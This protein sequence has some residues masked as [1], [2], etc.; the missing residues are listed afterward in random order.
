MQQ[1]NYTAR[2]FLIL[3]VAFLFKPNSSSAEYGVRDPGYFNSRSVMGQSSSLLIKGMGGA[4]LA[5]ENLVD[6]MPCNPAF[7]SKEKNPRLLGN[8]MIS[9]GYDNLDKVR[10]LLNQKPGLDSARSLL[11]GKQPLDIEFQSGVTFFSNKLNGMYQIG[12]SQLYSNMV[13]DVNPNI[14]L[15]TY[16]GEN[17]VLQW[18]NEFQPNIFFGLTG[19]YS[20]IKF[21]NK[22]F[23]LFDVATEE[24]KN[25][26]DPVTRSFVSFDTGFG[27]KTSNF[28]FSYL[29]RGFSEPQIEALG[30]G[31]PDHQVGL[32][33]TPMNDIDAGKIDLLLDFK[34]KLVNAGIKYEYGVMSL[35][36]GLND[37]GSSAGMF[38]FIKKMFSGI[39]FSNTHL[40]WKK[41]ESVNSVFTQF[42]IQI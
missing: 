21:I 29:I 12:H 11:Q 26:L 1:I 9:N 16:S 33:Y 22:S 39:V 41:N 2:I 19:R 7:V 27:Y 34:K 25:L 40:P 36:G 30:L 6:S 35:V 37:Y 8:L 38:F 31:E 23:Q 32:V 17:L 24:G 20:N 15:M 42:G 3:V 14:Q 4:C 5:M 28:T 10:I 13:G 18:G